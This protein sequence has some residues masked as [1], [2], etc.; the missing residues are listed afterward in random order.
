MEPSLC[1]L[2]SVPTTLS[3]DET[4]CFRVQ[5]C[6]LL[7][8]RVLACVSMSNSHALCPGQRLALLGTPSWGSEAGPRAEGHSAPRAVHTSALSGDGGLAGVSR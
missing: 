4:S 7:P 2:A 3:R 5:L 8:G 1:V 6:V